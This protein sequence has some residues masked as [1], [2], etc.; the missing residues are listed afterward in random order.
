[1]PTKLY[2]L[3]DAPIKF[4]SGLEF[5][6]LTG[7]DIEY[8]SG[9][10]ARWCFAN[11]RDPATSDNEMKKLIEKYRIGERDEVKLLAEL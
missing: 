6:T 2:F 7:S 5:D 3:G 11:R 4:G 9:L 1:M 8:L 10:L